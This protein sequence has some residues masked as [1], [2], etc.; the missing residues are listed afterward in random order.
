MGASMGIDLALCNSEEPLRDGALCC[1]SGIAMA[2]S[3]DAPDPGG[4]LSDLKPHPT[5]NEMSTAAQTL[6]P[7]LDPWNSSPPLD[8]DED[9]AFLSH[10]RGESS[11]EAR[12][13]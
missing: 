8:A 6:R 12:A 11:I 7:Q 10:C 9:P 4:G 2:S 1:G 3:A 13:S 5:A